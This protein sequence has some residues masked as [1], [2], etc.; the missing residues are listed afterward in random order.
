MLDEWAHWFLPDSIILSR[1]LT[2]HVINACLF[3]RKNGSNCFTAINLGVP[4]N[5]SE[6]F[7]PH[8]QTGCGHASYN[9]QNLSN[10]EN[11]MITIFRWLYALILGWDHRPTNHRAPYGQCATFWNLKWTTRSIQLHIRRIQTPTA[12]QKQTRVSWYPTIVK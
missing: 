10:I 5:Q 11:S 12:A 3:Y 7:L 9:S 1:R 4:W 8:E 2:L 6:Y